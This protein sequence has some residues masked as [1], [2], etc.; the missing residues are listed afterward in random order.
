MG[1]LAQDVGKVL[2]NA[3]RKTVSF[4]IVLFHAAGYDHP[5]FSD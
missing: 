5:L 1:V 4:D 3:V 2:P